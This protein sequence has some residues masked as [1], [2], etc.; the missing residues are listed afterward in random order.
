[1]GNV[2]A[3]RCESTSEDN[4]PIMRS[5]LAGI[6]THI[7]PVTSIVVVVVVACPCAMRFT[8]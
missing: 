5:L 7:I 4:N 6:A 8:P 1:M 2:R 3:I